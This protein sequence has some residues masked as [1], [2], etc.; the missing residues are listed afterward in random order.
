MTCHRN[1]LTRHNYTSRWLSDHNPSYSSRGSESLKPTPHC[2]RA[3]LCLDNETFSTFSLGGNMIFHTGKKIEDRIFERKRSNISD[4]DVLWNLVKNHALRSNIE[5][6]NWTSGY[7]YSSCTSRTRRNVKCVVQYF[8][9]THVPVSDPL[10]WSM[11]INW[12]EL[13][14]ACK[15]N[16]TVLHRNILQISRV[17]GI[18]QY[19]GFLKSFLSRKIFG[20]IG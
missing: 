4:A 14:S 10:W 16:Y 13:C 18:E 3:Y 2:S 6:T 5:K 7:A 1:L 11:R 15:P 9:I 19:A 12:F 8:T 17:I 20:W